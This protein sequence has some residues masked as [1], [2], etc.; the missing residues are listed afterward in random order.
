MRREIVRIQTDSF[1]KER[2][3]AS[4]FARLAESQSPLTQHAERAG[5]VLLLEVHLRE[6]AVAALSAGKL[7]DEVLEALLGLTQA[8]LVEALRAFLQS[9][10]V[11]EV[12]GSHLPLVCAPGAPSG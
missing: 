5:R 12:L 8:S 6:T 10:V 4:A 9:D 3:R 7:L 2:D 1:P 11:V